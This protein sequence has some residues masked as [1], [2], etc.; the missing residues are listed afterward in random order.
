MSISIRNHCDGWKEA[1]YYEDAELVTVG[2]LR[3]CP[4]C[5]AAWQVD[6]QMR[7]VNDGEL[8]LPDDRQTE[9]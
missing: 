7:V 4:R 9:A 5:L 8:V 6:R 3:L 2:W 1:H